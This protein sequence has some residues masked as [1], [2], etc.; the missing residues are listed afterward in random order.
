MKRHAHYP[1]S[2]LITMIGAILIA[3]VAMAYPQAAPPAPPAAAPPVN[4][5]ATPVPTP[6]IVNF[7]P[8]DNPNA[9]G[10]SRDERIRRQ[11][12]FIRNRLNQQ[13]QAQAVENKKKLEEMANQDKGDGSERPNTPPPVDPN[14]VV[15]GTNPKVPPTEAEQ[16]KVIVYKI[17]KKEEGILSEDP[18]G[19]H[20]IA[21]Y[22]SPASIVATE[23][24]LFRTACKIINLD[25]IA[26]DRVELLIHYPKDHVAPISIHQDAIRGNLAG[27]PE[28]G[29]DQDRGE[30]RFAAR[31]VQPLDGLD[32]PIIEI[33][34]RALRAAE[35]VSIELYS[36]DRPSQAWKG[37]KMLA[38]N[39]F[40]PAGAIAGTSIRVVKPN[41]AVPTGFRLVEGPSL[42]GF[43]PALASL[44]A[45]DDHPP[46]L[47]LDYERRES[48]AP[49][50]WIVAD[51][52]LS[53]ANF[54]PFD[55]LR[56]ALKF[57]PNVLE[58]ADTD[59]RNWIRSGTNILDG[60]FRET[61]NWD[62]HTRNSA[63]EATG[64]IVYQMGRSDFRRMPEG[65]VARIFVRVKR[66]ATEPLFDWVLNPGEENLKP[67]TGVYLMGENLIELHAQRTA[68]QEM[69]LLGPRAD[70][71]EPGEKADPSLYR[72]P[73]KQR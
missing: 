12:N 44:G 40:G 45:L 19:F 14:F 69:I 32:T 71:S 48:Y 13:R 39:E 70:A 22:Q 50:Q 36:G 1:P 5:A 10:L 64:M 53:N 6:E 67:T 55:E 47:W 24:E 16:N 63:D 28:W 54:T 51:V 41:P 30:I 3:C 65:I 9:P 72:Q 33:S 62:T 42:E 52:I 34:W 66:S 61:W 38:G 43:A 18:W 27:E 29:I 35:N 4:S 7:A 68:P 73:R 8:E 60:L 20:K 59:E 46:V 2:R 37:E 15:P 49:G 25:K 58:I 23:G 26:P 56:F 17:V 57:D 11:E 31:F 21:F